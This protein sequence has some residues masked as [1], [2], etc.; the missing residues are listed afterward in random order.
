MLRRC[1]K[2]NSSQP[3]GVQKPLFTFIVQKSYSLRIQ[4]HEEAD[5]LQYPCGL[6]MGSTNLI[7]FSLWHLSHSSGLSVL[8]IRRIVSHVRTDNSKSTSLKSFIRIIILAIASFWTPM[9]FLVCEY[10]S[11]V[12]ELIISAHLSRG[13][14][15]YYNVNGISNSKDSI[16]VCVGGTHNCRF[17]GTYVPLTSLAI[18]K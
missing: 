13:Q 18:V 3:K 8:T 9:G 5:P 7:S 16:S 17:K 6:R 12:P 11:N 2:V 1:V 10:C 15:R 4:K 14:V